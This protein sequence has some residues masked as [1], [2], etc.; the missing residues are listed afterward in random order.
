MFIKQPHMQSHGL[1]LIWSRCDLQIFG[2]V[3]GEISVFSHAA[4]HS[5]SA[6]RDSSG[7]EAEGDRTEHPLP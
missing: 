2:C 1:R 5:S 6:L 3:A 7:G 4:S